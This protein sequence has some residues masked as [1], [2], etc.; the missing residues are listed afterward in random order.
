MPLNVG[1]SVISKEMGNFYS[2]LSVAGNYVHNDGLLIYLDAAVLD[3]YA[4]SGG[5]WNDLSGR[6]NNLTIYGG[7]TTS[8]MGGATA[9]NL[10]A[11]G[12]YFAGSL[13]GTMPTTNATLEAWIYPGA[14]EVTSGDRGT[15]ILLSGASAIYMSWN[16]SNRYLSNYWYNHNPEGY[17]ETNGPSS[18]EAWTHWCSVWNNSSGAL[19]Q[20]VNGT[21]NSTSTV[22]DASTGNSLNIGRE[23]SGRQF[24]GGIAVIRIYNIALTDNQVLQNFNATRNRFG[25]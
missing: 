17:H 13:S 15:V 9:F 10:N 2:R 23:G 25:I 19:N 11:D 1:G 18:R 21:K 24:S 8:T 12:K 4:G 6:G 7:A 5:T 20:W 22:G 14:S 3:S 16:K